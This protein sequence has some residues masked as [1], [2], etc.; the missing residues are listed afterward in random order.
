[1]QPTTVSA[2]I[3]DHMDAL[4]DA[5]RRVAR[6]LLADYPAA[7]LGTSHSLARLVGVSAPTVV[8]FAASLG[9]G[10]FTDMQHHLRSEISQGGSSPV[11]RA[12]AHGS[13]HRQHEP[14]AKAMHRRMDAI[15]A[16]LRLVPRSEIDSATA[17]IAHCPARVLV[18]GGFFS[19]SIARIMALQLSQVRPEVVFV[20][21]PLR[22]DAGLTLDAK[23]RSVLVIFDLRRYEPAALE[24]AEQAK[25][26]GHDVVL[27]TDRGMSPVAS[28]ADVVLPVEAEAIPFDTFVAVMALVEVMVEMVMTLGGD[29]S[30]KRM[31]QWE[32]HAVSHTRTAGRGGVDRPAAP[33]TRSTPRQRRSDT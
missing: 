31:K 15:E 33:T 23:K 24:V 12:L 6:E 21:E 3:H 17:L 5:E 29:K 28:R 1:M 19:V 7:G 10:G 30:L 14:F 16:T 18:T 11:L 8:R 22:R 9:F 4:T 26:A 20:E 32:T 13:G 27:I 25:A 2:L